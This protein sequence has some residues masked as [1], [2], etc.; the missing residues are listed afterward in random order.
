MHHLIS[1]GKSM[2]TALPSAERHMR[3]RAVAYILGFKENKLPEVASYRKTLSKIL[4]I[5]QLRP[6]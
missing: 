1:S 5:W 4:K 3:A 2:S 6:P